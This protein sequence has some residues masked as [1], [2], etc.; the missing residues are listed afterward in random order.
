[1]NLR[2]A[3]AVGIA[4]V[5]FLLPANAPASVPV[6]VANA[7]AHAI[8]AAAL[9]HKVPVDLLLSIGAVESAGHPFALNIDG[10][11]VFPPDYRYAERV[12]YAALK[13]G[14]SVD[15]GCMQINISRH[16]RDA[17][18]S[19]MYALHPEWNADYGARFLRA[20]F[21]RHRNWTLATAHY[22]SSRHDAQV[23]YVAK[24]A[25]N[26]Q[27][28]PQPVRNEDRL[29]SRGAPAPT[30]ADELRRARNAGALQAPIAVKSTERAPAVRKADR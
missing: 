12:A 26:L 24:V 2:A 21:E 15:I 30:R 19:L 11:S 1:M 3:F 20:L 29:L 9:R 25:A 14:A 13:Q 18:P 6:G 28:R 4:G 7:C 16:H 5:V 17:F 10:K 8:V 22:H 27:K 23:R